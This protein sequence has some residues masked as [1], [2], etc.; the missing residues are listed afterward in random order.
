MIRANNHRGLI[1]YSKWFL[2]TTPFQSPVVNFKTIFRRPDTPFNGING[3]P[4]RDFLL[5]EIEN[6]LNGIGRTKATFEGCQQ[7][8]LLAGGFPKIDHQS[9][10]WWN[11]F[12]GKWVLLNASIFLPP[13]YR[14]HHMQQMQHWPVAFFISALTAAICKNT[15]VLLHKQM[16]TPFVGLLKTDIY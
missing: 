4:W 12:L 6:R 7:W 14:N 3:D 2:T 1:T 8:W 5:I 10:P 11:Y 16:Q 9:V 13:G 15:C